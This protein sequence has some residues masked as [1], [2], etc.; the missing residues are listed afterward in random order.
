MIEDAE[1][2]GSITPGKTTVIEYT[3]GN[4]GIGLAMVCAAKG[5]KCII[6]MPQVPPMQERFVTCRK[7]GAEVHLTAPKKGVPGMKQYMEEL[8]AANPDYWCPSQ[9][10]NE[11]NPTVHFETTGPEIW[12]QAG[13]VDYLISGVGTG[14]TVVG[15]GKFLKTKNADVKVVA[16]EPTE[17]RVNSGMAHSPHT[18][19]GMGPGVTNKFIEDLAPGQAFAE[20]PRGIIDEFAHASSAEAIQWADKLGLDEGLLVGPTTG[21]I[22]KVA[23]EVASRPEAAGKT[24]VM[25]VPSSGIRYVKHP[26]F[27]PF[28]KEAAEALPAPPNMEPEPLFRGKWA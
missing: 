8:M 3:S 21:A 13:T 10:T 7:F 4:T 12:S 5:Y 2:A 25:I 18:V 27:A 24:I 28:V 22:M 23:V 1:K 20:G 6:I 16:V 14:G 26:M 19:V 9:F 15:I 17:S 11:S